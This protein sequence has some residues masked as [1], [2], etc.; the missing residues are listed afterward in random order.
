M[1]LLCFILY[2][3]NIKRKTFTRGDYMQYE[4]LHQL[5]NHSNCSR[6]Y[7]LSL[8]VS[9]QLKLHQYNENIHNLSQLHFFVENIDKL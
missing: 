5:I 9:M 7:F 4:N 2:K 6:Q 1:M 3:I 8:P